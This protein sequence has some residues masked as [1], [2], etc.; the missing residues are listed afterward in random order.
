MNGRRV[1][2]T[3]AAG[4]IGRAIVADLLLRG[5]AVLA[6]DVDADGCARLRGRFP[7]EPIH[8]VPLDLTAPG[9]PRRLVAEAADR[10]GGLDGLVNNAGVEHR[11]P[12]DEHSTAD[13]ARVHDI[14]LTAPFRLARAAAPVLAGQP[15]AAIVNVCSIAVTGFAGQAAY[16]ASKG[17]LLSLTRALAVELGPRGVRANA[18]CPGFIDTPMLDAGGLRELAEKVAARLPLGRCGHPEDVA[19]AVGWLLRAEAGYI[20]GQ[21]LFVDGGMVRA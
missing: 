18:V 17:G 12:L 13:W 14:N 16:D 11:A 9:A 3:G 19:A 20:T 15:G 21:A 2:V 1:L 10:L 5:A 6:T 4:G 8:V 7:G